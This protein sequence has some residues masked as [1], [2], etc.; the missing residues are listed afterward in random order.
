M[1]LL[2]HHVSEV[3]VLNVVRNDDD[4]LEGCH[5]YSPSTPSFDAP[6]LMGLCN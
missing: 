5:S 3:T 4:T 1:L 6:P 2:Y